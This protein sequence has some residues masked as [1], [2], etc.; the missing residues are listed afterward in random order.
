ME[1]VGEAM[2]SAYFEGVRDPEAVRGKLE[3]IRN[4][5]RYT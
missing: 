2:M 1:D 5:G 4:R 3:D